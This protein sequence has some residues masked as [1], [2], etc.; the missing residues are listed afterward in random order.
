MGSC[1]NNSTLIERNFSEEIPG[2]QS[3]KFYES[4]DAPYTLVHIRQ[5]HEGGILTERYLK[6]L[7]TS[8]Y[9]TLAYFVDNKNVSD[10]YME[11]VFP[12]NVREKNEGVDLFRESTK[13]CLKRGNKVF[14]IL[15]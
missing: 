14:E 9:Q 1:A 11:G 6:D 4:L 3:V 13:P 15:Y 5:K 10:I 2:S 12:E 8:I 7:H